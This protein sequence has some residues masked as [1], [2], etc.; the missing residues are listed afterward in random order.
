MLSRLLTYVLRHGAEKEGLDIDSQGWVS[1]DELM[2]HKL[3]LKASREQILKVVQAC[4]K[5]RF[6]I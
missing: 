5:K 4:P 1:V 2:Q 6:E 3:F